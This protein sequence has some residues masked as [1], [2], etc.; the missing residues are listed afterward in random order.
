MS[1]E[2]W[3]RLALGFILAPA[4]GVC[5]AAQAPPIDPVPRPGSLPPLGLSGQDK[6]LKADAAALAADRKAATDEALTQERQKLR[7][8]LMAALKRL[9]AAQQPPVRPV[10]PVPLPAQ[11]NKTDWPEGTKPI[12]ALRRAMNL[13]RDNDFDAALTVFGQLLQDPGQLPREDRVFARYM[14]ASCLRRLGRIGEAQVAY[15]EAAEL[16]E[17]D[18]FFAEAATVQLSL[19]RSGQELEAQLAQ[20]RARPKQ[21]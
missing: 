6:R 14:A 15:R 1:V 4:I 19:I 11:K 2:P 5:A 16:A 10:T 3:R 7:A 9:E 21:K 17:Q 13:F 8:D 20:L 18:E 12:D